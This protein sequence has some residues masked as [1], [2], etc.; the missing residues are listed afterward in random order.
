MKKIFILLITIFVVASCGKDENTNKSVC[1]LTDPIEELSWL[2]EMKNTMTNCSCEMSIVQANYNN[3]TVFYTMMT[4]PLCNGVQTI[5]LYDCE[6]KIV[7][8]I[9]N[10][11]IS[12]YKAEETNMKVLYRCKTSN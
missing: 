2:K 6:G 5:I 10:S 11:E 8:T 9:A 7:K 12:S 1:N 3:Q 4:D